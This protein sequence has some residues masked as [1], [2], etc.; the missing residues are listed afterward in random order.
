MSTTIITKLM[1]A[2]LTGFLA[3]TNEVEK[4]DRVVVISSATSKGAYEGVRYKSL[5]ETSF[6]D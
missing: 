6:V 3:W 4:F 5:G 2:G 1:K